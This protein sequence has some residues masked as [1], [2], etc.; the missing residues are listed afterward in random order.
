[1]KNSNAALLLATLVVGCNPDD[2]GITGTSAE[3]ADPTARTMSAKLTR[4]VDLGASGNFVIL[5]KSGI[6]TVPQSTVTGN[7]GVSPKIGRAHV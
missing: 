5:G 3:G 6:S 1:M 2:Q 4:P 7:I